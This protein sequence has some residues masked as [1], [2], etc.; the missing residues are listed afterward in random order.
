[1]MVRVYIQHTDP[2]YKWVQKFLTEKGY[3]RE[4]MNDCKAI[5]KKEHHNWW[6]GMRKEKKK[7]VEYL[8]S[9]G[10]H[11]FIYKGKKMWAFQIAGKT[12]LVGW[13]QR[14][15]VE[16]QIMIVCYGQDVKLV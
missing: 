16:E 4:N 5:I 8:P 9:P 3:L 15:E 10:K 11:F 1:M 14:P 6:E 2:V 13:E 12:H 7:E